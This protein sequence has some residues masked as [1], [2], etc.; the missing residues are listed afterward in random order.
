M[1][2]YLHWLMCL[3]LQS[4][5]SF[6]SVNRTKLFSLSKILNCFVQMPKGEV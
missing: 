5:R 3:L 2:V 6:K 1:T 4:A